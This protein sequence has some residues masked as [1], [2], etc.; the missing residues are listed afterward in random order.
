MLVLID[1]NIINM[2]RCNIKK[3]DVRVRKLLNFKSC[4]FFQ[5]EEKE[6]KDNRRLEKPKDTPI[7]LICDIFLDLDIEVVNEKFN[8]ILYVK[9]DPSFFSG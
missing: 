6:K 2:G 4:F 9:H 5:S 3:N 1:D 8:S 7:C